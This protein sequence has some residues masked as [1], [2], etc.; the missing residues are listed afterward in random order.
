MPVLF[1]INSIT[2]LTLHGK[3][4]LFADD[5]II[6]QNGE[7][8]ENVLSNATNHLMVLKK[9]S[10]QNILSLNVSKTKYIPIYLR[11]TMTIICKA[12]LPPHVAIVK[13]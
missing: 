3:P 8:W 12:L 7:N 13:I 2:K 5:T 4:F 11:L 10:E 1:L 6:L 9:W